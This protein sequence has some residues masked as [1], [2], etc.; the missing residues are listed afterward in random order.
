MGER[1]G[2]V[3]WDDQPTP[4]DAA[5]ADNLLIGA[6]DVPVRDASDDTGA[7]DDTDEIRSDIEQTRSQ[8]STTIDAITE[9][10]SP[11]HLK[12]Q[13]KEQVAESVQ[14]VKDTVREATIGK[15]EDMVRSAGETVSDARYTV[16]ETIKQNPIPAA[17]AGLG[18]GW[19][20]MNRRSA[21]SRDYPRSGG[22]ARYYDY[23]ADAGS[24]G[25][26]YVGSDAR[27]G[28]RRYA[29]DARAGGRA[30]YGARDYGYQGRSTVDRMSDTAGSMAGQAR[31]TAGNLA[32]QAA[33]TVSSIAGQAQ[34][35]VSNVASQAQDTVSNVA[36]QAQDTA[37]E[38]Y[39]QAQYQAQRL[40]DRFERMLHESPLAVGAI[41][42]ALG[43]AV[44]L[45]V[46]QTRKEDELMGEARDQLIDKAQSVASDT[47]DKVQQVAG[48]VTEQATTTAKQAAQQQGLTSQAG[49]GGQSQ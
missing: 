3:G 6:N 1:S 7:T 22:R 34:D 2:P 37:G 40:E 46:P 39:G 31:D 43:A 4:R 24:G 48:Q 42:I 49:G 38:L 27:Y 13:V 36:S 26:A 12:D 23:D 14:D 19:L 30:D 20:W 17:L 8:M 10:L 29:E 44:G 35:T 33:D 15:A 5:A 41:S 47:M 45:A 28:G 18:L 9:R 32:S 21:P 25:R 11:D 16:M